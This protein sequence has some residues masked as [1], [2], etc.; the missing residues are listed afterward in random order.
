MMRKII[1]IL[2]FSLCVLAGSVTLFAS[3]YD[4]DSDGVTDAND[5]AP[6][7]PAIHPGAPDPV[8]DGIDTNCDGVDGIKGVTGQRSAA[9]NDGDGYP[10]PRDCNDHNSRVHPGAVDRPRNMIDENCDGLDG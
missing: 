9:D 8:G 3:V 6:A 5:C 7:D 1:A 2:A 4:Y 10:A